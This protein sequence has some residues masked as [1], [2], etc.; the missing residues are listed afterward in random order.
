MTEQSY[1]EF[2]EILKKA[3]ER[4]GKHEEGFALDGQV[5]DL[6]EVLKILRG[7][8]GIV[9]KMKGKMAGG[10]AK[11]SEWTPLVHQVDFLSRCERDLLMRYRT[12][13]GWMRRARQSGDLGVKSLEKASE[14]IDIVEKS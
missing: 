14:V 9:E 12:R 6:D 13:I 5:E 1:T 11:A 8:K 10:D 3:A 4:G 7:R 2:V